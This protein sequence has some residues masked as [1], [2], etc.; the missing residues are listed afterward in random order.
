[1]RALHTDVMVMQDAFPV[2]IHENQPL[3][4][5][6]GDD[7]IIILMTYKSIREWPE[8]ERPREVKPWG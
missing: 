2:Q 1:M 7:T 4:Y 5:L 8:D 6:G 3:P